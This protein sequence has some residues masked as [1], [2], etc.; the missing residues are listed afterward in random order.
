MAKKNKRNDSYLSI[1]KKLIAAVAMLLVASFMVASSSYAWFTLSTAPE[2]TG[3]QTTVG[4]NG[5][6]EIA[7][8]TG[9]GDDPLASTTSDGASDDVKEKNITWGNLVDL[10][11]EAYGLQNVVLKPARLN[12]DATS[13]TVGTSLLLVPVY[14]ADGRISAM[15]DKT[16]SGVYKTSSKAFGTSGKGVRGVGTTT[17]MTMQ[18]L[19]FDSAKSQVI[20]N[21]NAAR[22]GAVDSLEANGPILAFVLTSYASGATEYNLTCVGTMLTDLATANEKIEAAIRAYYDALVAIKLDGKAD[23]VY[24]S[25]VATLD[26]ANRD[27]E[28]IISGS[29]ISSI[30]L[31][32]GVTIEWPV[33]GGTEDNSN[34]GNTIKLWRANKTAISSAKTAYEAENDVTALDWDK[35]IT[36]LNPLINVDAATLNGKTVT[37]VKADPGSIMNSVI[38]QGIVIDFGPTSGVYANIASVTKNY[39]ANIKFL[40]GTAVNI[41]STSVDLTDG[42]ANMKVTGV[43]PNYNIS[44][45]N[46]NT[47]VWS[48]TFQAK[49][50]DTEA[51]IADA[52]AYAIDL[53]FRTNASGS[54]LQLQT[55]AVGRIYGTDDTTDA[56]MGHGATMSFSAVD[57]GLFTV[58]Q[59]KSLMSAVRIVFTT[60]TDAGE[61]IIAVGVLDIANVTAAGTE[62]TAGIK[63]VEYSLE[64]VP[65][66]GA[67]INVVTENDAPKFKTSPALMELNQNDVHKL[68]VLVF[69]DG[70]KVTNA[71]VATGDNSVTGTL[72]LQ[73]SSDA[74]L[75]PM[76]YADLMKAGEADEEDTPA[77]STNIQLA[78]TGLV[79]DANVA[80]AMTTAQTL[81]L[82]AKSATDKDITWTETTDESNVGTL[83]SNNLTA[84]GAGTVVLGY[85]YAGEAEGPAVTG[86]VTVTVTAAATGGEGS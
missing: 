67:K 10:S 25:A 17:T 36:I 32:E 37:E 18:Q 3:I 84:N 65:N 61:E 27:L 69:L 7:L 31:P 63:L 43:D 54:S 77:A 78:N 9:E 73:F 60:V 21:L 33:F 46:G 42:E 39:Q 66:A 6:L 50:A 13:G 57:S 38:H 16:V 15:N 51:V 2:V 80:Q 22:K 71:D 72:N 44:A 41:G 47:E 74:D 59:V 23:S 79:A 55:D 70:D 58:D 76:E 20:T 40:D 1:R 53:A 48:H 4:A 82:P 75:K 28:D 29:F 19:A 49:V 83:D 24:N 85:S 52:Y 11:D 68:S 8:L 14:G 62:L 12:A 34:I 86:T 81:V 64:A 35:V 56:T 30:T 26:L 45:N 5:S